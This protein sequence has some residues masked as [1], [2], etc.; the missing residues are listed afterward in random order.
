MLL[1]DED[2]SNNE[3]IPINDIDNI[4]EDEDED[5]KILNKLPKLRFYD[6]FFNNVY[7]KKCCDIKKQKL[8]DSC[9][10]ILYK[11]FSVE[12]IL[13]NQIMFENL[14]KDYNWNNLELKSIQNNN[15][16]LEVKKYV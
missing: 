4:N 5:D 6:Y 3:N 12:N 2:E 10:N 14:M 1:K 9:S 15:L 8:I 13:Y 7:F 16:I 11:Y